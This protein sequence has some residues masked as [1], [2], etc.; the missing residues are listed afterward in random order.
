M[1][2]FKKTESELVTLYDKRLY[3]LKNLSNLE[4]RPA[5][6]QEK[7]FSRLFEAAEIA[8]FTYEERAQYQASLKYYQDTNNV[9]N[10]AKREGKEEGREEGKEELRIAGILKALKSG[11]LTINEIADIFETTPEEV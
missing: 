11:K 2:K 8:K 6:L 10:T 7:V 4:S 5:R 3:V 1:P 9:I